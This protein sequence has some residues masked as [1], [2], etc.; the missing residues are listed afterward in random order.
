L[1]VVQKNGGSVSTAWHVARDEG[2]WGLAHRVI[3]GWLPRVH[4]YLPSGFAGMGDVLRWISGHV[5]Y[6]VYSFDIFDT[7]LR[8]KIDPPELIHRLAAERTSE[9]LSAGGVRVG[10]DEILRRRRAVEEALKAE[11]VSRG[12][13]A[14]CVLGQ[15]IVR[16]LRDICGGDVVSA[17]EIVEH[18]IALEKMATQPMPGA[19]AVLAH[20][21][22]LG[23]RVVCVSD[24]HLSL[25]Q[26]TA[27][28]QHNGLLKY[29][30]ELYLSSDTGRAKT[31]GRLFRHVV[32]NE[33]ASIVHIGDDYISDNVVPRALGIR[34]LWLNNR[35]ERKRR[36]ELRRL[37]DA[38]CRMGYVNTV[39]KATDCS[40]D[41]LY[42]IGYEVLGPPLTAFVHSVAEQARRDAVEKL[43]FV[44]RDG[45]VMK[46]IYDT[47]R[48]SIY[49]GVQIP[50]SAY[51][52]LSRVSARAASLSGFGA[53]ELR[54][55]QM[56]ASKYGEGP[57]SLA[58]ALRSYGLD[59]VAFDAI[60]KNCG[61]DI[62]EPV[63][64]LAHSVGLRGLL[65]SREFQDLVTA[66]ARADRS[67]L[68]D[69]LSQIGFIGARTAGVVDANSEGVTQALLL[70]AFSNNEDYPL[71]TQY[72]FN[73]VNSGVNAQGF[74][75]RQ[76]R[77]RGIVGDWRRDTE[78]EW[79]LLVRFG[80][81]IELFSHPAHGVTVGY[82]RA[83]GRVMPVFRRTPQESQHPLTSRGLKGIL[84]YARDYGAYHALHNCDCEALVKDARASIIRWMSSPPKR[85]A[86][87][88]RA[89]FITSDWPRE[90]NRW[91][92]E[93]VTVR[94]VLTIRGLVKKVGSS[95]WPR[96]ALSLAPC[97]RL[98]RLLFRLATY[99]NRVARAVSRRW[100]V[101][102]V[103]QTAQS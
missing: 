23:K 31:T 37:R 94:D 12:E 89:L 47:L 63:G 85:D 100:R 1:V 64:D 51:M 4:R 45:Y 66:K 54:E 65:T 10:A 29:I 52:C 28:L 3:P 99:A 80:L 22:S 91:L 24:T 62:G 72:Y 25:G 56:Y 32:D 14:V 17:E 20:V 93:R 58:D 90:G 41:E 55:A 79:D 78:H 13:D 43:F 67:V 81:L 35:R 48:G 16:T 15:V 57:L 7:V 68:L 101:Q 11:A 97:P 27:V 70:R 82:K 71:V 49:K 38:A 21:R 84:S 69:Y 44:A 9:L 6:E 73:L 103:H 40:R 26:M 61:A 59:P 83:G 96:G 95:M 92:I 98:S 75:P 18:E 76:E 42:R 53:T 60:A 30:D 33:G 19:E 87:P 8:R 50:P 86:Q 74:E 2:P 88:L 39:V 34:V 5:P 102:P 77:A 36:S 46:K